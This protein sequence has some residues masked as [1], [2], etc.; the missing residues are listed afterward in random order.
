MH[1]DFIELPRLA[2]IRTG[3]PALVR[4]LAF[5]CAS[6]AHAG[7]AMVTDDAGVVDANACQLETTIKSNRSHTEYWALPAC[8]F[9]GNLELTVGG[10]LTGD[11]GTT[12]TSDVQVQG[13]TLFKPLE[14]N[15]WGIGLAA[16]IDRHLLASSSALDWYAYVPTS[17]SFR[18]DRVLLHTN[19]GWLH[20]GE[21]RRDHLTW[22]VGS[23]TQLTSSTWLIA[24]TFGQD[25]DRPY[26]QVGLRHW[27]VADSVQ[28]DTVYGNRLDSNAQEQWV[29]ICLHVHLPL[30]SI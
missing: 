25:W 15:G 1:F 11:K 6:S 27:L 19:W 29:S 8:N 5:G 3:L 9:T 18:D 24:E 16:G 17:F 2:Q 22:G 21:T 30:L 26:Y 7:G 13:K 4:A 28:I 10:A 14:T 20:E 23:E 12:Q